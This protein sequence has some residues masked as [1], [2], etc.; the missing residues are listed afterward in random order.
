MPER[1]RNFI[2]YLIFRFDKWHISPSSN[3]IYP[4]AIIK[5]IKGL[6]PLNSICEIGCGLGDII[7]K[8]DGQYLLGLD[9]DENVLRA[10]SYMHKKSQNIEFK[11]FEFS[12][13]VLEGQ[14]D[15]IIAV[16]W[17]HGMDES[18]VKSF[19]IKYFNVNLNDSGFIIVDTINS[20][21]YK[22]YHNFEKY[23]IGLNCQI[24]TI[25]VFQS[26]R[27]ILLIKKLPD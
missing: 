21:G 2:L 16:N 3:R 15:L 13:S 26:G 25:G 7:S 23:F 11:R 14:F 22:Y 17:L 27:K 8:L 12:T 19:F 24:S 4:S 18:S 20:I 10:A 6:Y 1:M 5:F 9:H